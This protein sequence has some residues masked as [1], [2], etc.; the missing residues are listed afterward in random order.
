M[1]PDRSS[2]TSIDLEVMVRGCGVEFI[3]AID[4][5]E[6]LD[7]IALLKDAEQ[8]T[9]AVDGGIAVIIARHDCLMNRDKLQPPERL[10]LV[11]SAECTGCQYCIINFECP[12]LQYE[13]GKKKVAIDSA[14]CTGC[15]VC[16][17]V[18]PVNAIKT[19]G[20]K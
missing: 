4:P 2:G 20:K 10:P 17:H 7:F 11:V 8:Y 18:C 5:Y 14:L 12:A 6:V 1:L 16:L 19:K 3:R 9:R 15:A 13:P